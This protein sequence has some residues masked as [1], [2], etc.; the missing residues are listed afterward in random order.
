MTDRRADEEPQRELLLRILDLAGAV[1]ARLPSLVGPEGRDQG[2]A[3]VPQEP[4]ARR[5]RGRRG[6]EVAGRTLGEDEDDDADADQADELDA[7]Q[8]VHQEGA[9]PDAED[10]HGGQDHDQGDGDDLG[11]ES[12]QIDEIGQVLGGEADGQGGDRAGLDDQEQG[13]AEEEGD[14]GAVG[15]AEIDIDPAGLG[16][17]RGELG[18][19]QGAEEAQDP[20]D[21]PDGQHQLRR[22]DV[23]GDVGGI[24]EDAGTDHGSDDDPD[25]AE[26]AEDPAQF[27]IRRGGCGCR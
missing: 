2:D 19:G 17:D 7:R 21:D 26:Q 18:D 6:Q 13:P 25:D 22:A 8:E 16:I 1:G 5:R 3:E 11:L 12:R 27:G 10:V 14:D 15:L 9:L 4:A 20:A 24:D 23:L